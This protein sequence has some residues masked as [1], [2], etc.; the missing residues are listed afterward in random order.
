MGVYIRQPLATGKHVR[1]DPESFDCVIL[2][3][4]DTLDIHVKAFSEEFPDTRLIIVSM[5][6]NPRMMNGVEVYPVMHF[7]DKLWSGDLF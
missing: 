7:L 2:L 6:K 4:R 5:D 1:A 3:K